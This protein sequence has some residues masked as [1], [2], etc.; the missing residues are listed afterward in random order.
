MDTYSGKIQ[1]GILS[2]MSTRTGPLAKTPV[3]GRVKSS[4]ASGGTVF[5]FEPWAGIDVI[6]SE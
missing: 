4:I 3:T 1:A 5:V 2:L 6:D